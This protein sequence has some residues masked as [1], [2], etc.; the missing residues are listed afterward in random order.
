MPT[1]RPTRSLSQALTARGRCNRPAARSCSTAAATRRAHFHICG[2]PLRAQAFPGCFLRALTTPARATPRRSPCGSS[3]AAA[4]RRPVSMT[5]TLARAVQP[6]PPA[7]RSTSGVR[8]LWLRLHI[9]LASP[10]V[11][12]GG[13]LGHQCVCSGQDTLW[14]RPHLAAGTGSACLGQQLQPPRLQR[15]PGAARWAGVGYC[16]R[17]THA[18]CCWLLKGPFCRPSGGAPLGPVRGR[19]DGAGPEPLLSGRLRLPLLGLLVLPVRPS[20][21]GGRRRGR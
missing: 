2:T 11:S 18:A 21:A 1:A 7:R 13:H 14:C 4:T 9:R 15:Q 6:A 12:R 20:S 17:P 19:I 5:R 3:A 10:A 8:A 16:P